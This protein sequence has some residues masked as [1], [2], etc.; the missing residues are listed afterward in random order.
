MFLSEIRDFG[1][2]F[3]CDLVCL[4][5][6]GVLTNMGLLGI[7]VTFS[8]SS[9]RQIRDIPIV[10]MNFGWLKKTVEDCRAFCL[11]LF[12]FGSEFPALKETEGLGMIWYL[13]LFWNN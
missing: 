1:D 3:S 7:Y 8:G 2:F 13:C 6:S 11:N 9:G 4:D 10:A 5:F 12:P